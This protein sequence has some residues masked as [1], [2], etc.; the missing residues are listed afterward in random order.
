MKLKL[1][2]TGWEIRP[3]PKRWMKRKKFLVT[4][5]KMKQNKNNSWK[6]NQARHCKISDECI[7]IKDTHKRSERW[8]I[9][10]PEREKPMIQSKF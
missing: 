4:I 10:G 3:Y 2:E 6:I 5:N 9:D 8:M 7:G 1:G